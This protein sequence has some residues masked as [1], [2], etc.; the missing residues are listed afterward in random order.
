MGSRVSHKSER[1][2]RGWIK[3]GVLLKL[4]EMF[5]TNIVNVQ[6]FWI[7][8]RV[9][10]VPSEIAPDAGSNPVGGFILNMKYGRFA[11]ISK[12]TPISGTNFVKKCRFFDVFLS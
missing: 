4:E 10:S 9:V 5:G 12:N 7:T 8:G 3:L 2:A 1:G 6:K 11:L